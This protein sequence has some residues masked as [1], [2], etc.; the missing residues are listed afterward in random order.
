M[1]EFA[2]TKN[3][4]TV[5]TVPLIAC[6]SCGR[7]VLEEGIFYA[8]EA[9]LDR[10]GESPSRDFLVS[11][12]RKK[13]AQEQLIDILMRLEDFAS[14]GTLAVPRELNH[15]KDELWEIKAGNVRLPFYYNKL[16]TCGRIRVTHGFLKASQKTPLKEI[17]RG[18]AII[19]ED[20]KQ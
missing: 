3:R 16:G 11:L 6:H 4:S 9:A 19:R 14:T 20:S 17:D 12:N 10:S 1:G 15:L 8:I 7:C 2:N 18:L 13:K 5:L